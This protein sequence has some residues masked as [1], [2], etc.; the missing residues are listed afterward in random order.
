ME[1]FGLT[2]LEAMACGIPVVV[3]NRGALPE[4]V[5]DAGVVIEPVAEAVENALASLV[6]DPEMATRLS[7]AGRQRSLTMGWDRTAAA[8]LTVL[9]E[10]AAER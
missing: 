6:A 5:D 3:S 9:E 7:A 2:A 10:A 4:V 1:G 8:W